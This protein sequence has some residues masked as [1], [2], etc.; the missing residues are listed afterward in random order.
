VTSCALSDQAGNV[1]LHQSLFRTDELFSGVPCL[2][3]SVEMEAGNALRYPRRPLH[4]VLV[5]AVYWF[6]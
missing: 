2:D 6:V 5:G 1:V 3:Q 4:F